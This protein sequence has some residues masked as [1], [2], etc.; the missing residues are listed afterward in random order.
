MKARHL[1]L[2]FP[3]ALLNTRAVGNHDVNNTLFV[4]VFGYFSIY[5]GADKSN[6]PL[7]RKIIFS[8][9]DKLSE[10]D[11][12]EIKSA[13]GYVEGRYILDNEDTHDKADELSGWEV[14]SNVALANNYLKKI[15]K[16]SKLDILRVTKKY[17]KKKY[18]MA[19]IEQKK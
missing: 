16:V 12:K 14:I 2:R 1:I 13:I 15:R 17:L 7:T 3:F 11:S 10:L 6:L 9:I 8:E 4:R 5:L 19:T 18:A